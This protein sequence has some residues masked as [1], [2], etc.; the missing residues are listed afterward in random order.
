MVVAEHS[1]TILG[2]K[3]LNEEVF[4]LEC[5]R[6]E[7]FEFVA[8]QHVT[9]RY[10]EDEREYTILSPPSADSLLFL[11]KRIDQGRLSSILATLDIGGEL[12]ISK[13]MGYLI[14]RPTDRPIYFVGTG[15]GIAPFV[16][17]ARAGV[18][19]FTLLHGAREIAG[20]FFR[21]DLMLAATRYIP[22]V[23]GKLSPETNVI[24]LHPGYVTDYI[25]RYVKPGA[26]DFYLCG[27]RPMIHDMTHLLDQHFPETRIYSEAF[28]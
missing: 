23:S 10:Q 3:W 2:R 18:K 4:E 26:Y 14:Y 24:D 13:A 22:C 11:I 5:T 8:G 9:M 7:G 1:V 16:S 6:P 15:V 20:L 12:S 27:S 21:Q 17:M 28:N 19:N 25:D